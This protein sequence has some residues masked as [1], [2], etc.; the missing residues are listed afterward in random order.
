MMLK[1]PDFNPKLAVDNN[2]VHEPAARSM[3]Q[4]PHLLP[5]SLSLPVKETLDARSS[6]SG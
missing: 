2:Q 1:S 4:Q 3:S 6:A 5:A